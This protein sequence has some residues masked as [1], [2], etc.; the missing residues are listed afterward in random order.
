MTFREEEIIFVKNSGVTHTIYGTTDWTEI[1][2][3]V[4]LETYGDFSSIVLVGD[5]FLLAGEIDG[6]VF[7][8]KVDSKSHI[9][10]NVLTSGS[11][12]QLLVSG[13]KVNIII[14]DSL[15]SGGLFLNSNDMP[16]CNPTIYTEFESMGEVAGL[17]SMIESSVDTLM[18]EKEIS[19]CSQK[20][21][22]AKVF[23]G[24]DI[25]GA[26]VGE[27]LFLTGSYIPVEKQD[28]VLSLFCGAANFDHSPLHQK[29]SILLSYNKKWTTSTLQLRI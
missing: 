6:S 23:V 22:Y 7:L 19:P 4:S 25:G 12:P 3:Y 10:L 8:V 21:N 15:C 27:D 2:S 1:K 11:N 5:N 16:A 26:Y 18:K 20:L 13:D 17:V 29:S 9:S 14:E 28:L 24:A